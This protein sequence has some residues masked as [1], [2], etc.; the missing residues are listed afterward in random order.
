MVLFAQDDND[1]YVR[2]VARGMG[3]G[4]WG[5]EVADLNGDEAP[6]L[7]VVDHVGQ[8]IAVTMNLAKSRTFTENNTFSGL[9]EPNQ[10]VHVGHSLRGVAVGRFNDDDALDFI[11]ASESGDALSVLRSTGDV[12]SFNGIMCEYD[13]EAY[14]W[15]GRSDIGY[16]PGLSRGFRGCM[17]GSHLCTYREFVSRNDTYEGVGECLINSCGDGRWKA[18][19]DNGPDCYI[20]N[21]DSDG[22]SGWSAGS[23]LIS[24][25]H[26]PQSC[27]EGTVAH[28]ESAGFSM[29]GPIMRTEIDMGLAPEFTGR[30]C[31][32]SAD[33]NEPTEPSDEPL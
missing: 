15:F 3:R 25:S 4:A 28:D 13:S 6:D 22:L 2:L 19:I 31:C 30:L 9:F 23:D 5:I 7:L 14:L 21:D 33:M 32:K 27:E 18:K 20:Q 29:R 12:C 16:C 11:V 24:P 1:A 10:F 8:N 17:M 26:D